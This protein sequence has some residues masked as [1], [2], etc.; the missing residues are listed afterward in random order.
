[1]VTLPKDFVATRY[2]GYFWHVV[3]S[4]WKCITSFE[5]AS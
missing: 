2:P 1:M 5:M 4:V 3:D